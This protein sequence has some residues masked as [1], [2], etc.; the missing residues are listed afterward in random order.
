MGSGPKTSGE[1]SG[2][3]QVDLQGEERG[4]WECGE[5]EGQICGKILI[6]RG[7]WL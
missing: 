7:D 3:M 1:V 2:W 4:K 6:G 5:I